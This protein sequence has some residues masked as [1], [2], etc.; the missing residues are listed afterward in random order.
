[1]R[2]QLTS[3]LLYPKKIKVRLINFKNNS[4]LSLN[5]LT[6]IERV[7]IF[8]IAIFQILLNLLDII[9]VALMGAI[10]YLAISGFGVTK[11]SNKINFLLKILN[12]ENYDAR[13][14]TIILALFASILFVSKSLL[15]ATITKKSLNFLSNCSVR[16]SKNFINKYFNRSAG[17]ITHSGKSDAI[18]SLSEGIDLLITKALSITIMLVSDLFLL[19]LMLIA[20]G[21]ADFKL[22]IFTVIFFFLITYRMYSKQSKISGYFGYRM[23]ELRNLFQDRIFEF[24]ENFKE[25]E[26]RGT[27]INFVNSIVSL[28]KEQ[29]DIV[30]K[31]AF[32]QVQ[33]KYILESA[34]VIGGVLLSAYQ[35][36]SRDA[37]HAIAL[38][39]VFIAAGTRIMPSIL[40]IQNSLVQLKNIYAM[41]SPINDLLNVRKLP[42]INELSFTKKSEHFTPSISIKSVCFNYGINEKFKLKDISLE[43]EPFT[44][45]AI[46]GPT[47]SGKSTLLDLCLGF[48]DPN[49][50]EIL[51]NQ[52][53]PKIAI[54]L[55]AGD[56]ALISQRIYLTKS[57]LRDNL[58]LGLSTEVIDD[59]VLLENLE[60][61]N[62]L[63]YVKDL[64]QG[65]DSGLGEFGSKLS[66]GQR[67]RLGIARALTTKPKLLFIDEGTSSLD[68]ETEN[69]I[70]QYLEE[71]TSSTTIVSIAH[72]LSTVRKADKVVYLESGK[73]MSVGTF[74]KVRSDIPNFD[75]QA[76]LLGL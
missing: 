75:T 4:L 73:I 28:R 50:G 26:I 48:I 71:L 47:G 22:S 8:Y 5:L 70:A 9:A 33:S 2:N 29:S 45:N 57:S 61:V 46:V 44:F 41:N 53:P 52:M 31:M 39:A 6:H 17:D 74:D 25:I 32:L 11:E 7:K 42:D 24:H 76:R 69:V 20:L 30:A 18:F 64:R 55:F 14:Q 56:L 13:K 58:L 21:I 34:I 19:L 15:T 16:I 40:R 59:K 1:M 60:K 67:Q 38:L 37:G 3:A 35:F 63:E 27:K 49:E 68:S 62:L 72:R 51:I 10:G 23:R 66:G 43:I 12:I 65:L 54:N 36:I